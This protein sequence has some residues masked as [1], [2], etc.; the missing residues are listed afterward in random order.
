MTQE[1][2]LAAEAL[3]LTVHDHLIIAGSRWLSF[4]QE[5]LL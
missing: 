3:R 4:R 5:G 1:M 2:R